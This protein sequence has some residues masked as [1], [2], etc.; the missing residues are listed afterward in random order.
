MPRRRYYD[1]DDDSD[2]YGGSE[3]DEDYLSSGG[4]GGGDA[5]PPSP[6]GSGGSDNASPKNESDSEDER[7]ER[8]IE[9]LVRIP[10]CDTDAADDVYRKRRTSRTIP[11]DSTTTSSLNR[12]LMSALSLIQIA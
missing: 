8:D 6:Y 7:S 3:G 2:Q 10:G 12:G 9:R 1:S 4:E 11:G 5:D